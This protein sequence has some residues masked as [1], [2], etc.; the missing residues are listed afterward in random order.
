MNRREFLEYCAAAGMAVGLGHISLFDEA[1]AALSQA[2]MDQLRGLRIADAHAHPYQLHGVTRY[3]STTPDIEMMKQ[4]GMAACSFSAVGD[5]TKFR[6]YSGTPYG[7]TLHQLR[8]VR[9]LEDDKTLKRILKAADVKT[10]TESNNILGAVMAIEGGDALESELKNL[11]RY[12]DYG[13][14]LITLMHDHNNALGFNQRSQSDGLLT[15]FGVKVVE[16][17]NEQGMVID[18]AHSKSQTLK[19]IVEV[20]KAPVIDSHTNPLPYGYEAKRTGRLRTWPEMEM[21]AK[22]G[23]VICTWPYA[24]STD[25][26][27]RTTLKHWAEEILQMK[28]RLG[29]EH[30]GLGTDGGGG[31][32]DLVSGWHSIASLPKLVVAMRDVGLSQDDI[33]AY[34]GGNFLRVL[35]KCLG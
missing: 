33:S 14:R 23:G 8:M 26:M 12:Y 3:D 27:Q 6:G 22:T 29:I 31:L 9:Q 5:M 2:D 32:P 24:A 17:M 34:V 4:I 19:G 35:H 16:R 15:P 30:C 20:S 18:V 7:H 13:V 21:I 28:T 1:G 10:V 11:D 25:T